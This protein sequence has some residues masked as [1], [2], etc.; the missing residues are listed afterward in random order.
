MT[1]F[2]FKII[3]WYKN[4]A[5]DL[6]WRKTTD[7]YKIWISEV[8]LQQTQVKQGLSYYLRFIRSFP[9]VQA[10]AEA[11]E[12]E[13]LRQWQG[14]GYY[15]RAR[16]LHSAA[17]TIVKEQNSLFPQTYKKILKLKGIGP[18]TAAA[19]ASIAF[20]EPVPVIDGNVYRVLSRLFLIDLPIDTTEGK[21]Y[22]EKLAWQLLDR[23]DP[24]TYNQALMELGALICKPAN[25]LCQQCPVKE[26]CKAASKKQQQLFPVKSKK[27]VKKKRWLHYLVVS[28]NGHTILQKRTDNDIWKGLY[29]FP[30][31][32][33]TSSCST[34][35]I[36]PKI[37][38]IFP[39]AISI[40][41][42]NQVKHLL[43]HQELHI[44]FYKVIWPE[45]RSL[46]LASNPQP[47]KLVKND[48]IVELPLPQV[49]K[50]NISLIISH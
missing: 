49:I 7:P 26:F 25:P 9:D 12:Q 11:S 40:K 38:E 17:K 14:L 46:S 3:Q 10:L 32:E 48:E 47:L 45:N 33:T 24:G 16:N 41:K 5:R 43:T 20:G 34:Q 28:Q 19:I 35:S 1:S 27:I 23:H 21:K 44:S 42:I 30:L 50:K 37:L 2:L 13:V 29:Q 22:F 4:H 18:Y 39:E 8:I 6:P 15:S 31:I 36:R